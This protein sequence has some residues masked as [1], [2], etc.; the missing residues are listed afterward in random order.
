LQTSIDDASLALEAD[1]ATIRIE[2]GTVDVAD[3]VRNRHGADFAIGGELEREGDGNKQ[4]LPRSREGMVVDNVVLLS[5]VLEP[6]A[7]E[8]GS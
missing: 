3:L 7:S 8:E 6:L 4:D 1:P 2:L 5:D